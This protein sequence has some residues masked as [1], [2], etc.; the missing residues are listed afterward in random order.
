[1]DE[2]ARLWDVYVFEGDAVLIRAAVALIVWE[3]GPLLGAASVE[4]VRAVLGGGGASTRQKKVLGEV[5]AEDRW[6]QAVREA[7]KA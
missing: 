6:M 3:E 5:G 2:A 1:M 4:D 7:G